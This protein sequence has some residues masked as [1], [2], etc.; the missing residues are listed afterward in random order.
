[1]GGATYGGKPNSFRMRTYR[2]LDLKSFRMRTYEKVPGGPSGGAKAEVGFGYGTRAPDYFAGPSRA[3]YSRAAR[4]LE[5]AYSRLR[6]TFRRGTR[7]LVS[8]K[9]VVLECR[10]MLGACCALPL[11]VRGEV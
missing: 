3:A 7:F 11:S 9:S 6:H 2:S 8:R 4:P 5:L 1:V 10:A